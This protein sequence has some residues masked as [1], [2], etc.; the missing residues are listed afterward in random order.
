[1]PTEK[2][3]N[4]FGEELPEETTTD[5]WYVP[6]EERQDD[7]SGPGSNALQG[8]DD[9]GDWTPEK[10][11]AEN[12][13]LV[14]VEVVEDEAETV[15]VEVGEVEDLAAHVEAAEVILTDIAERNEEEE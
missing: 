7:D 6:P 11:Y 15:E 1:M 5:I 10:Y 9:M 14:P 2:P 13:D 8:G 3:T 4:V 12:P